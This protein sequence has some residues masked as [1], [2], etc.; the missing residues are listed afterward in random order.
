MFSA[1]EIADV[2]DLPVEDVETAI[3]NGGFLSVGNDDSGAPLFS[4]A[5]AL[6][7]LDNYDVPPTAPA[8]APAT[9]TQATVPTT[10]EPYK[11]R[12]TPHPV[13]VDAEL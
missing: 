1:K 4:Q 5:A 6:F 10:G 8:P 9:A 12:L 3:R 11:C 2:F 7:V 13:E